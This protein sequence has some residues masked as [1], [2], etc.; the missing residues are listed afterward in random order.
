MKIDSGNAVDWSGWNW[1]PD[2][3]KFPNFLINQLNQ[4]EREL[5]GF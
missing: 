4:I 1:F 5:N 3:I 2:L